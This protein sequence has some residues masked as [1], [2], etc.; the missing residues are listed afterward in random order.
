[1]VDTRNVANISKQPQRKRTKFVAEAS[2]LG[3]RRGRRTTPQIP[4]FSSLARLVMTKIARKS[5][6]LSKDHPK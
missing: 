3:A 5:Q 6:Q 1:M 4:G 2:E